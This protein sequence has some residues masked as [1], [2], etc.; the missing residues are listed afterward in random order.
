MIVLLVLVLSLISM[1][2]AGMQKLT[3]GIPMCETKSLAIAAAWH[4][5]E[6]G[7]PNLSCRPLV[8]GGTD[9]AKDGSPGHCSMSDKECEQTYRWDGVC[10]KVPSRWNHFE[11]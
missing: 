4:S 8:W 1:L 6:V 11:R 2:G 9:A 7:D 10:M 5:S 3:A